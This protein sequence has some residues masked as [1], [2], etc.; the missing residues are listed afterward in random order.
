MPAQ[1]AKTQQVVAIKDVKNGVVVLKN[2]SLRKVIF[3]EGINFDLKS[4][5]EQQLITGT[6]Q[7]F[8]NSLDFSVQINLHSRKLNIED[9]LKNLEKK[10]DEEPN[11]LLKVQLDEYSEFVKSFVGE[12]AIMAKSF[13]VVV[14]YDPVSVPGAGHAKPFFGKIFSRGKKEPVDSSEPAVASDGKINP[15]HLEQLELRVNQVIDNLRRV[16]LRAVA[17]NDDELV[18]LYFNCYNPA[19]I[20]KRGEV[21]G[22][23]GTDGVATFEDIVA[24]ASVE[25]SPSY[26]KIGEKLVKTMFV[27]SYPRYLSTGWFSPVIN[28]PDLVDVSIFIHPVDTGVAMRNLRRKTAQIESQIMSSQEKGQVRSP[29][30]ETALRDVESLRDSL[31]TA[32]ERLFK[33]GVYI[34]IYA[35]SEKELKKLETDITNT[36]DAK[37][38]NLKPANYEQVKGFSSTMPVNIDELQIHTPLNSSPLSSLFPFISLATITLWLFST[39]SPWRMPTPSSSEKP[40]RVNHMPPNWRLSDQ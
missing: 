32:E 9:Y 37:L 22:R 39:A 15:I 23:Q 1:T 28:L 10:R 40:V 24:P 25:V 35:D 4:E 31:Q 3:V 18:E 30:L 19:T 16:G 20:E 33:V 27:F 38:I 12:N 34:T 21:I 29:L 2:G 17:L 8:L 13:F 5:E 36:L 6:Y 7:S 11:E 14:P 26:L